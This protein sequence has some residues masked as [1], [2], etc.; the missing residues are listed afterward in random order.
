MKN[1]KNSNYM[2]NYVRLSLIIWISSE[3]NCLKKAVCEI[4]IT[5][6]KIKYMTKVA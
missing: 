3:R 1:A 5:Y 2:R 4:F 6:V